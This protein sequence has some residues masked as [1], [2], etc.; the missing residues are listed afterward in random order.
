M[1]SY[2]NDL[3]AAKAI[4]KSRYRHMP[5]VTGFGIGED[6][7]RVYVEDSSVMK[8][9]PSDLDGIRIV[10]VV[11]GEISSLPKVNATGSRKS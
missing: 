3:Q 9:L 2:V 1:S 5:G 8:L 4:V 7:I 6:A 10:V 11:T